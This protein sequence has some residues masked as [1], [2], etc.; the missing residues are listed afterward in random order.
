MFS[1]FAPALAVVF[2]RARRADRRLFAYAHHTSRSSYVA[3][4]T[5]LRLRHDQPSG[6]VEINAKSPDYAASVWVGTASTDFTDV[7]V[8]TLDAQLTQR[9]GWTQRQVALP[10]GRYE[11]L[12]PP[13]AVAELMLHLYWSAG[14]RDA[15]DGR[16]VFS[17][18]GGGTRLS[19]PCSGCRG[20]LGSRK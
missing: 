10:G 4:S 17:K 20:A 16:T 19:D 2:G 12:L 18:P 15:Y 11:T 14:A 13:A 5:G 9:L 3:S 7:D 1:E 6:Y 8:G